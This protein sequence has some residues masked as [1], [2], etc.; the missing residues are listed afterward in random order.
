M[1]RTSIRVQFCR[2]LNINRL[3]NISE[4]G[5]SVAHL[6][7]DDGSTFESSHK[8]SVDFDGSR[9]LFPRL[10]KSTGNLLDEETEVTEC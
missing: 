5:E 9:K 4:G 7:I 1:I 2:W 10:G 8:L 6:E 3:R